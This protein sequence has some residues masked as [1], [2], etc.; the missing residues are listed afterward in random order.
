[1]LLLS[2]AGRNQL[3]AEENYQKYFSNHDDTLVRT[4]L[5]C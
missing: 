5:A 2:Q 4:P 1:L 3:S